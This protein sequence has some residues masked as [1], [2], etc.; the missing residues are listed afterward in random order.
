VL[1]SLIKPVTSM[2]VGETK[3]VVVNVTNNTDEEQS[4]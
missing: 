1:D 2:G 4:T 3:D